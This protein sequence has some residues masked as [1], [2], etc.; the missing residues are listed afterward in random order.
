MKHRFLF[1][2]IFCCAV[3]TFVA[4]ASHGSSDVFPASNEV[5]SKTMEKVKDGA[6]ISVAKKNIILPKVFPF[7]VMPFSLSKRSVNDASSTAS[8]MSRQSRAAGGPGITPDSAAYFGVGG[9]YQSTLIATGAQHWFYTQADRSGQ[10]TVHLDV[11]A[12][13]T[14]DY[15]LYVYHYDP[16]TGTLYTF[17]NS[18]RN[19]GAAE[20]VS[21][22]TTEGSY[23]FIRVA[24]YYGGGNEMYYSLH[25]EMSEADA[26]EIDDFPEN[27]HDITPALNNM[28]STGGVIS[29]RTDEDFFKFKSPGNGSMITFMPDDKNIVADVYVMDSTVLNYIGR[30]SEMGAYMFSTKTGATY[31]ICVRQANNRALGSSSGYTIR[32]NAFNCTTSL[33]DA[34]FLGGNLDF[35]KI[36]YVAN[37][38]LFINSEF[39]M[40][41]G[42]GLETL[43]Q[44]HFE[45]SNTTVR[46]AKHDSYARSPVSH[47]RLISYT[48]YGSGSGVSSMP[49][50]LAIYIRKSDKDLGIE[51]KNTANLYRDPETFAAFPSPRKILYNG[52]AGANSAFI[53]DLSDKKVK[54]LASTTGNGFYSGFFNGSLQ[55]PKH[56]F[57]I[58]FK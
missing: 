52:Y 12:V 42:W 16:S 24:S 7:K 38:K 5:P 32:I 3:F 25:V 58:T 35:S 39:V 47:V 56:S 49:N 15:D 27:A 37:K 43:C 29:M 4:D 41:V 45:E 57:V 34:I 26:K 30:L 20:H 51:F 23:Y 44:Y 17:K 53:L 55:Y 54:D 48:V 1:L 10:M 13:S 28:E 8:T 40:D 11:P 14:V 9:Y 21:F 22:M 46:Q 19:P 50:A 18:V 31:Y 33:A 6:L 2:L 36:V